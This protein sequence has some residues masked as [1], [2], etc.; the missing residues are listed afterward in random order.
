MKE[1]T[2]KNR[3]HEDISLVGVLLHCLKHNWP[4]SPCCSCNV[5]TPSAVIAE[6]ATGEEWLLTVVKRSGGDN[7]DL[8]GLGRQGKAQGNEVERFK[9]DLQMTCR[10]R[11]IVMGLD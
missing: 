5:K 11:N 9:E 2:C 1:K 4:V 10:G 7:N 8:L 3:L 6:A